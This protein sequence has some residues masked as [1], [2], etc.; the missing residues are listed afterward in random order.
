VRNNV[1]TSTKTICRNRIRQLKEEDGETDAYY[2]RAAGIGAAR[3][4]E[5]LLLELPDGSGLAQERLYYRTCVPAVEMS[6]M[7]LSRFLGG[8]LRLASKV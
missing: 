8:Y 6:S 4:K 2:C 1:D 5:K 3:G 7:G